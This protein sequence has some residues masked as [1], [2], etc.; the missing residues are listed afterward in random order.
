MA[1][2]SGRAK[3]PPAVGFCENINMKTCMHEWFSTWWGS[4]GRCER[5]SRAVEVQGAGEWKVRPA[6]MVFILRH[7]WAVMW[8]VLYSPSGS[9]SRSAQKRA[10]TQKNNQKKT[11]STCLSRGH[12]P[13]PRCRSLLMHKRIFTP[14]KKL[15]YA[16][17]TP[18]YIPYKRNKQN[19]TDTRE[20]FPHHR[21]NYLPCC[22]IQNV[23]RG[24]TL[25]DCTSHPLVSSFRSAAHAQCVC[26]R[27]CCGTVVYLFTA[28]VGGAVGCLS[29]RRRLGVS[30]QSSAAQRPGLSRRHQ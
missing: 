24:V 15:V 16:R 22:H 27:K 2:K 20:S 12:Y 14:D 30:R 4:Q 6:M 18:V 13:L 26:V 3:G 11:G 25:S 9:R 21:E 29:T 8:E 10:T 5:S 1:T 17:Q 19:K 23:S 7:A 28:V